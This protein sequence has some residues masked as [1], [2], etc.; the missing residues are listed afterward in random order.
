ME[1]VDGFCRH[2]DEVASE[3]EPF[4]WIVVKMLM[5]VSRKAATTADA[6]S[7]ELAGMSSTISTT[8]TELKNRS[9]K[10][11]ESAGVLSSNIMN[12]VSSFVGV[13]TKLTNSIPPHQN[14]STRPT[15]NPARASSQSWLPHPTS[16]RLGSWTMFQPV[17]RPRRRLGMSSKRGNVPNRGKH[18]WKRLGVVKSIREMMSI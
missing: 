14:D 11:A 5:T 8:L 9:A 17:L 3:G 10:T 13:R 12:S 15:P 4:T 6:Q 2:L 16:S 1:E 7:T 18:C